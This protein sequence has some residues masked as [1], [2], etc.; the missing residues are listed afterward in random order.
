MTTTAAEPAQENP[1]RWT[2]RR[3]ALG[4]H[5]AGTV[6]SLQR[7]FHDKDPDAVAVLARM[8]RGIGREPGFDYTLERYL[9]LPELLL[10]KPGDAATDEEHAKH[11]AVTLYALHQQSQRTPMHADHRGLG[12]AVADLVEASDSRDGVRRRFAALGTAATFTE[13]Q[14]HLRGL[15]VMLREH[16]IPIDYGL[17]A[18]DLRTLRTPGGRAR[19]QAVWGREFFRSRAPKAEKDTTT[20]TTDTEENES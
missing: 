17:L 7:R 12:L 11:V 10:D 2:R 18:D 15:I 4:Q 16:R 8:R 20:D 9:V 5:V 3:A 13:A 1:R 14:Q 6:S 19:I